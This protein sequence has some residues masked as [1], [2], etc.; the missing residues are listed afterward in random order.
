[1]NTEFTLDISHT[2]VDGPNDIWFE[3]KIMN[4]SENKVFYFYSVDYDYIYD[5]LC[6]MRRDLYKNKSNFVNFDNNNELNIVKQIHTQNN[7]I[8]FK[9]NNKEYNYL[10]NKQIEKML[11]YMIEMIKDASVPNYYPI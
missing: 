9:E 6:V 7:Y 1:M 10:I 5:D 11:D 4:Y 8:K 2:Y 3:I